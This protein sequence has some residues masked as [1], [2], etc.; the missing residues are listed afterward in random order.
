MADNSMFKTDSNALSLYSVAPILGELNKSKSQFGQVLS[1]EH[2]KKV[3]TLQGVV[4]SCTGDLVRAQADTAIAIADGQKSIAQISHLQLE[5]VKR[6][7]EVITESIDGIDYTM[8]MSQKL[9]ADATA[10]QI[11]KKAKAEAARNAT[12]TAAATANKKGP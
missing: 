2:D 8:T 1:M 7:F 9:E 5:Q 4:C 6:G 11:H 12:A 3:A 10:Y